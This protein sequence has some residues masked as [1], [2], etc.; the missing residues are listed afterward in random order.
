MR[1]PVVASSQD[2]G[3][4]ISLRQALGHSGASVLQHVLSMVL[5]WPKW[6]WF[7]CYIR[8]Q[9]LLPPTGAQSPQVSASAR[10]RPAVSCHWVLSRDCFRNFLAPLIKLQIIR[11]EV[12]RTAFFAPF[13][14]PTICKSSI[15]PLCHAALQIR[16]Q[17]TAFFL[18]RAFPV[19]SE[20]SH[21]P[22]LCSWQSLQHVYNTLHNLA[23]R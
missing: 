14:P 2:A 4:R 20:I 15:T 8:L 5:S 13:L 1:C 9:S 3:C 21:S 7:W 23:M 10:R 19:L 18:Q 6:W 12:P 22:W 16:F 11:S 17:N